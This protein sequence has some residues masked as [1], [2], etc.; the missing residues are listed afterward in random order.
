MSIERKFLKR[1]K[2]LSNNIYSFLRHKLMN[3]IIESIKYIFTVISIVLS[4]WNTICCRNSDGFSLSSGKKQENRQSVADDNP[5]PMGTLE[6]QPRTEKENL[7]EEELRNRLKYEYSNPKQRWKMKDK[8]LH[9]RIPIK[10]IIQVLKIFFVTT[11][12]IL[13]GVQRTE[14]ADY[15]EQSDKFPEVPD[16]SMG[17][18]HFIISNDTVQRKMELCMTYF[19]SASFNT[20]NDTLNLDPETDEKRILKDKALFQILFN[21]EARTVRK[22]LRNILIAVIVILLDLIS[23]ILCL[24][25]I[26]N[27]IRLLLDTRAYFA[28][29]EKIKTESVKLRRKHK[30][31]EKCL[32]LSDQVDLLKL[33]DIVFV[34]ND[35]FTIAGT[36]VLL[37]M[38]HERLMEKYDEATTLLGLGGVLVWMGILRYF[39][40]FPEFYLLFLIIKRAFRTLES[41]AE[42]LFA[43]M[44]GDELFDT[45][46]GITRTTGYIWWFSRIYLYVFIGLFTTIA[47]NLFIAICLDS[48]ETIKMFCKE[49]FPP[50][51]LMTFIQGTDNN[52]NSEDAPYFCT[53]GFVT[54]TVTYTEERPKTMIDH[55]RTVAF[56]G[57]HLR[58]DFKQREGSFQ[59]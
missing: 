50:S 18:F 39:S 32:S 10:L 5:I 54:D 42:C 55:R 36:C 16:R 29:Q 2:K 38:G 35:V 51:V 19:K 20:Y 56:D 31:E 52:H 7:A 57:S 1:K 33:W 49:G 48:Y 17:W 45:F 30:K 40:F 53:N 3:K 28:K 23:I 11:Q 26:K 46:V 27:S 43:I 58:D 24:I 21:N 8:K 44:N 22:S 25:S 9:A 59:A 34:I 15:I 6:R 41:T 37:T 13:V 4:M 12:L 47:L 14:F